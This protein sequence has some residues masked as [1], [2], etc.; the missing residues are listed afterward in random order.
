MMCGHVWFD[1]NHD[2]CPECGCREFIVH[3]EPSLKDPDEGHFEGDFIRSPI[4][5]DTYGE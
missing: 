2:K 4:H 5:E 3:D 1:P